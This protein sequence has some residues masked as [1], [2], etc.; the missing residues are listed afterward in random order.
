M[1]D[2]VSFKV[3]LKDPENE[4]EN[5]VRRFVVDRDVST[6]FSYL[7]EKLCSV[8]PQLKQKIFSVSW[9]DED[10]DMVTIAMDEELIIALTEMPGPVYKLVANV[11]SQ[12]KSENTKT[13]SQQ[14]SHIHPGVSCDACDKTPIEGNRYKCVVCDDYDLCGSCE[15]AGLHPGHN[16]MRIASPDNVFPQRLFKRIHKM[17]ERCEK[18]RSRHEKENVDAP[19]QSGAVPPPHFGF[20]GRGRGMFPGR[21]MSLGRGI[22][23]FGG[24]RGMGGMRGGCGV[25]AWA[26]PTFDAMMRGW[27]GEQ[28]MGTPGKEGESNGATNHAF[29][30]QQAHESAFE[31]AQEA[32]EQAHNAANEA[33][34][35]ASAASA[36]QEAHNAAFEQFAT[37]TGSADYLQNVGNFVAAALDPLG[38]DVQ[39]DIETPEGTRN[40]VKSSTRTTSSTSS[41]TSSTVG[42]EKRPDQKDETVAEE[43]VITDEKKSMSPTPSDDDEWTVVDEK[44]EEP[45]TVQIPIKI[46]GK[47]KK[48]NLYPSLPE[49]TTATASPAASPTAPPAAP[50]AAV[51]AASHPDPKIQIA[52]QAMM[53]MGFSNEG[54]WL[55]SLL[56]AK[57]GDIGKVLDILQPVKK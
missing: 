41:A 42:E 40:T 37:M 46:I 52:L 5:E 12:K 55:T 4:G 28:P 50:P 29:E 31:A 24:M 25:G 16:M 6:S 44:K 22:H 53:N 1:A 13:N 43:N 49:N 18:S 17:Q 26:G 7:E 20:G 32:H 39:V 48:G 45:K 56:E 2:N 36:A 19:G 23:G 9:T 27:M 57:N 38:I 3:F 10:G 47:E 11:K 34:A 33:A 14:N 35:A 15:A 54:G 30:H 8:F 21:G 51:P